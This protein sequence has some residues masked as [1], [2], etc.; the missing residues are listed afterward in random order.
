MKTGIIVFSQTGNTLSVAEKMKE[1]FLK[2]GFETEIK[3]I[4]QTDVNNRDPKKIEIKNMPDLSAYDVIIFAS[5]VQ[6]FSLAAVFK[7]YLEKIDPLEGKVTLCY[8]TKGLTFKKT[9]GNKAIKIITD[10][11]LSKGGDIKASGIIC[12]NKED[13]QSAQTAGVI[14]DFYKQI[15]ALK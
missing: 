14:E 15:E 11:V 6:A 13:I 3:Q 10:I 9:G 4:M 12:W 5:P 2:G 1:K 8:V 7:A